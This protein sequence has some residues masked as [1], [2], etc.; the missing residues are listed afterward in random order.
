MPLDELLE[1]LNKYTEHKKQL[2]NELSQPTKK[3][4]FYVKQE[5]NKLLKLANDRI[6]EIKREIKKI[7][8]KSSIK[9][10]NAHKFKPE[11]V[12][13][14]FSNPVRYKIDLSKSLN[15]LL[16]ELNKEQSSPPNKR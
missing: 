15:A 12:K 5:I 3:N 7:D 8:R 16:S 1:T 4:N 14:P 10:L 9:N 2:L 6:I 13:K 11:E